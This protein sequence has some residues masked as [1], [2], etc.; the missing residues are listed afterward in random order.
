VVLQLLVCGAF[1]VALNRKESV[2][3]SRI[4]FGGVMVF[5]L[6]CLLV[7]FIGWFVLTTIYTDES[8]N[9]KTEHVI[10]AVIFIAACGVYFLMMILNV[11]EIYNFK[12]NTWSECF[13]F[14]SAV[15][16]FVLA[17]GF[18][19]VFVASFFGNDI[20]YGWMFEHASFVLLIGAHVLLFVADYLLAADVDAAAL[21]KSGYAVSMFDFARIKYT[22]V[23]LF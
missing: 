6:V 18:G 4:C 1:V 9:L 19:F 23:R 8:G 3:T 20:S 5:E 10:G 11:A 21:R 15:T 2:Y 14:G 17:M 22:D 12:F 16:F 7:A 13:I